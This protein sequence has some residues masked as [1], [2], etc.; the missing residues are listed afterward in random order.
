MVLAE[1]VIRQNHETDET[2]LLQQALRG[3][4]FA[5]KELYDRHSRRLYNLLFYSV[6][7]EAAAQDLLQTVFLKAFN[8]LPSFNNRSSFSTWLYRIAINEC[9]N[10]GKKNPRHRYVS[11]KAIVGSERESSAVPSP[12]EY[13]SSRERTRLVQQALMKLSPPLRMVV[14][15]R[16]HEEMS[17]DEIAKVLGCS[18]GTVASRLN[19]ALSKI[20]D[21]LAPLYA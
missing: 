3:S 7:N 13:C 6:A 8:A 9:C 1:S 2:A 17:Y 12:E 4:H 18:T 16:Y 21:H 11:L 10:Y 20:G 15:L 19:R 5:M 14:V